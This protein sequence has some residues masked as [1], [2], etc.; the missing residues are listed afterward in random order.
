MTQKRPIAVSPGLDRRRSLIR[1]DTSDHPDRVEHDHEHAAALW[2][3]A[4]SHDALRPTGE[5]L[6][7]RLTAP[8]L[9]R[10]GSKLARILPSNRH[11]QAPR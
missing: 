7:R 10:P 9:L 1:P 8:F 4:W 6:A 11:R 5:L 3:Y 2:L